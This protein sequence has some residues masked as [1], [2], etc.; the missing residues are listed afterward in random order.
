MILLNWIDKKSHFH[1]MESTNM[2]KL[3]SFI[4]LGTISLERTSSIPLYRQLYEHVR[5]AILSGQ[6]AAGTRLPPT[7]E[8]AKELGVSRNTV[9]VAFDQLIAEGYIEGKV[10]AGSYVSSTL[11]DDILK[12]RARHRQQAQFTRP[13]FP[14]VLSQRGSKIADIYVPA[15]ISTPR[16]FRSGVPALDAFPFKVWERLVVRYW[17]RPSPDLLCYG[18]PAGYRP[19]RE[20]I[21]SYLGAARGVVCGP[22]QVIIVTGAQKGIDLAGRLLLDQ[23]DKVWVEDPCY[24]NARRALL[25]T[26]AHPIPVPV[27]KEGLNIDNAI[28]CND[29]QVRMAYITPSYQYPLGISMSLAR[30][31]RLLEWANR[32]S[33]WILEDDYDSEY[34]Y[35]GR[36]LAAL[37]GLDQAGRVI[38]IG[39]FSKVLFPSLR[40]GYVVVPPDLV[41]PF[42]TALALANRSVPTIDQAVLADFI[43]EGHFARHIRRMRMLYVERQSILVDLVKRNLAGIVEISPAEAGLHLIGWLKDGDDC[44]ISNRLAKHGVH[45][46]PVSAY[47]SLPLSRKGLILGYAGIN[48]QQMQYGVEQMVKVLNSKNR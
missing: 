33:A 13:D 48:E 10:G 15:R 16:P 39:T 29:S 47:A 11:P 20:A 3:P 24:P 4:S 25:G 21:A 30:R 5:N 40:L 17:R 2:P 12:L 38:Y 36:P 1:Q 43:V 41:D 42:V 7:R 14:T 46:V 27:D 45:A 19:L 8:F 32:A 28:A 23:G 44:M 35:T 9:V 6:L 22:E 18:H 26:G 34:R 37:Q 31:L